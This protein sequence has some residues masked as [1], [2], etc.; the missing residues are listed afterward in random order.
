VPCVVVVCPPPFPYRD[1]QEHGYIPSNRS[2][3]ENE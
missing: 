1:V 2:L 3:S